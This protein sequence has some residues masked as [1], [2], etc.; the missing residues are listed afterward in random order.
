MRSLVA[1]RDIGDPRTNYYRRL[2]GV[3]VDTPDSW[4]ERA[5]AEL[6][7]LAVRVRGAVC[8][9]DLSVAARVHACTNPADSQ[10]SRAGACVRSSEAELRVVLQI[11]DIEYLPH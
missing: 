8:R 10:S 2:Y 4:K 5:C 7:V 11:G 9:T 1:R 3:G 6:V